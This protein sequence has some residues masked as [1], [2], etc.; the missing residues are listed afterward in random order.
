M[1]REIRTEVAIIGAGTAGLYALR[2]VRRAGRRFV[3]IDHGPLGTTCARVGCMP[4]KVALHA[5]ELWQNRN[6]LAEYGIS[7]GE[8]LQLDLAS[9]WQAVRSRRDHYSERAAGKARSAAGEHLIDGRARFLEPT[10][11]EVTSSEETLLIRADAVVIASGS[12]P[13]R[14][15]WLQPVLDRTVSTDALFELQHLP[16]RIGVLGLGA[17]GLEMGLALARLGVE[18]TAAGLG[19]L[20]NLDD[21]DVEQRALAHF[22]KEMKLWLGPPASVEPTDN[23]VLLRSGEQSTEVDLLLVA[24]G[25]RPNTD[26]LNLAGAGLPVDERGAPL[27][28]PHTLQLGD[29]PVFIAGDASTLRPLLHEAADEGSLAGYNAARGQRSAWQ[30]RVPLGIV[31]SSP[32]VVT[33]GARLGQLPADDILIGTAS[34]ESNGRLRILDGQDA[35]I[36]LYADARTGRLLGATLLCKDGEHLGHLLAW[37]IQRGET[38]QSLLQ[39]PFYHPVVEELLAGALQDIARHFPADSDLPLG[40]VELQ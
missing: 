4:S 40:V 25:R 6:E 10:L 8:A 32:D 12:R 5:A 17:I 37:A 39:M 16:P 38:A 11:L 22:G 15:G 1:P 29:A 36:H 20:A 18:V 2:E 14:P 34:G 30:R 35:L 21:E 9:A 23:G 26:S 13:I 19:H 33:V 28:D 24:M 7:G 27:F 31:F 3:L